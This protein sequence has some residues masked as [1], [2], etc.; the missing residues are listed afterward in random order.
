VLA[1]LQLMMTRLLPWALLCAP[2]IHCWCQ[3][4]CWS[5]FASCAVVGWFCGA[6]V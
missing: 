3:C 6:E 4:D 5:Q 1:D 2:A